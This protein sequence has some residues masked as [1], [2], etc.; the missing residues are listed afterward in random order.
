MAAGVRTWVVRVLL[1]ALTLVVAAIAGGWVASS[2]RLGRAFDV[3]D[4]GTRAAAD[5][6]S[7]AQGERL[8]RILGCAGCHEADLG[9][10]IFVEEPGLG[11]ITASNL[12]EV[13]DRYSDGDFER[14]LRHGVRPDGSTVLLA[15]PSNA[16]AY[17]ADDDVASLIAFVRSVP[18]VQ[19]ELPETRVGVAL[20]FFSFVEELR[21]AALI[22]QE[23]PHPPTA[24]R[25]S[26]EAFG[27]YLTRTICTECHGADLRGEASDFL[28]TPSLGVAAGYTPEQFRRLLR[29]GV[30][31]SGEPLD[32]MAEVARGRFTHYTDEE[33]EAIHAFARSLAGSPGG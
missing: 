13:R 16:F 26:P 4:H 33:I 19:R 28:V 18:D 23:R 29:E 11:R 25:S 1:G 2:V 5:S 20:R 32:L 7:V 31:A 15:M 8:A 24:D 17:L 12:T 27:A 14:L 21:A 3:P 30:A 10:Q 9:G 22:D 6:T